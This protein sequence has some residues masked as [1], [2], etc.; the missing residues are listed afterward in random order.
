MRLTQ[1]H[2]GQFSC[3]ATVK[4]TLVP[5]LLSFVK[6]LLILSKLLGQP[7]NIYH[8]FILASHRNSFEIFECLLD[9]AIYELGSSLIILLWNETPFDHL[10][11]FHSDSL[12]APN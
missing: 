8:D 12:S 2:P 3:I 1:H 10:D 11:S 5:I 9:L 7:S 6:S 4:L